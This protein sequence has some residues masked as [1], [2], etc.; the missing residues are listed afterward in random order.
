MTSSIDNAVTLSMCMVCFWFLVI[1]TIAE[2]F[3]SSEH[4]TVRYAN[5]PTS[6]S[7]VLRFTVGNGPPVHQYLFYLFIFNRVCIEDMFFFFLD[8]FA[9][10]FAYISYII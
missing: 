7:V 10:P 5:L 2:W 6:P 3:E 4:A 1:E 8:L 9:L